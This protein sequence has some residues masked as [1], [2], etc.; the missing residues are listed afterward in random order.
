MFVTITG[1]VKEVRRKEEK[2]AYDVVLVQEGA[3]GTTLI[4]LYDSKNETCDLP[5][6]N[7]ICTYTG[8]VYAWYQENS[9]TVGKMIGVR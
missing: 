5:Q 4:R 2:K 3:Q 9:Q 8:S 1:R 6:P 7:D